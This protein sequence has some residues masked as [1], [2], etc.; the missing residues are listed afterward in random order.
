M[1]DRP[2]LA[3]AAQAALD[4]LGVNP[5]DHVLALCNERERGIA[6]ALA[7]ASQ[8]RASAVRLIEYPTLSR[9]GEEPPA[10]VAQ[11]MLEA[12]AVFATT[13]YSI[14]HTKAR[15]AATACGARIASMRGFDDASAGAMAVDYRL[16]RTTGAHLAA[17]L[18]AAD[19]C[20]ITS[21]AGTDVR[22]SITGQL[23]LEFE[24]DE[25]ETLRLATAAVDGIEKVEVIDPNGRSLEGVE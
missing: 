12:S 17:A 18:T 23:R 3:A 7:L 4:C 1:T 9:N 19:S 10:D 16:L 5:G 22:L 14:S 15:L 11:A 20:R 2:E 24:E 21:P 8:S 25:H 13:T 6:Q